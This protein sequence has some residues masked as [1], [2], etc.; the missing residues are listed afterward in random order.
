MI[1]NEDTESSSS[2]S[3]T[4]NQLRRTS[5]TSN[6]SSSSGM[7]SSWISP[8]PIDK[9]RTIKPFDEK[10]LLSFYQNELL[11]SNERIV[12]E[13]V[14]VCGIFIIFKF[15]LTIIFTLQRYV[16]KD[17]NEHYDSIVRLE[18]SLE[19]FTETDQSVQRL[20]ES[21]S[22]LESKCWTQKQRTL[23]KSDRCADGQLV[24]SKHQYQEFNFDT[25]SASELD[26]RYY[27]VLRER[28]T[29]D[30]I[31]GQYQHKFYQLKFELMLWEML[32]LVQ[33]CTQAGHSHQDS[34]EEANE[35]SFRLAKEHLQDWIAALFVYYRKTDCFNQQLKIQCY[36]SLILLVSIQLSHFSQI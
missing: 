1:T 28:L 36:D 29:N 20:I 26:Q 25:E 24:E 12:G 17:R 2:S 6:A 22:E 21:I 8:S 14:Q 3:A 19:R 13:F 11:D 34:E 30:H 16:Q 10:Q 18:K 9:L 33:R 4:T 31:V 23:V 27:Y 15:L 5:L 7:A 35:P 32:E